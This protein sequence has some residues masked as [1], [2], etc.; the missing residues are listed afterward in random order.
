MNDQTRDSSNYRTQSAQ[1][2]AAR[3]HYDEDY[4]SS[5]YGDLYKLGNRDSH[6]G[7]QY[8]NQAKQDVNSGNQVER[9]LPAR[10]GYCHA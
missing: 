9:S 4:G 6:P 8:P 5:L 2:I 3:L 7:V 10:S 1:E